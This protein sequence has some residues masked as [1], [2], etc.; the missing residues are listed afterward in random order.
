MCPK[1]ALVSL[2]M[3]YVVL[4]LHRWLSLTNRIY[5]LFKNTLWIKEELGKIK[6]K[7]FRHIKISSTWITTAHSCW[8]IK[9]MPWDIY[10]EEISPRIDWTTMHCLVNSIGETWLFLFFFFTNKKLC[11]IIIFLVVPI[12]PTGKEDNHLSILHEMCLGNNI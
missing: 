9:C 11:A 2:L 4:Y 3:M 6:Y 1:W 7:I 12:I 5:V 8:L 10:T